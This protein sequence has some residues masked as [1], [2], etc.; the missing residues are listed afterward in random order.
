MRKWNNF[1]DNVAVVIVSLPVGSGLSIRAANFSYIVWQKPKLALASAQL[2]MANFALN[3]LNLTVPTLEA[4]LHKLSNS[5]Q[6]TNLP[7]CLVQTH[8]SNVVT[9]RGSTLSYYFDK[10]SFTTTTKP[11]LAEPQFTRI[12]ALCFS[13]RAVGAA[14]AET[15]ETGVEL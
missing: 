1:T 3:K 13:E 10:V 15:W 5:L 14:L 9:R 4:K 8:R 6:S 12:H 11:W 2:L 7:M